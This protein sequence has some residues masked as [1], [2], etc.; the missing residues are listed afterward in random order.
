MTKQTPP[1][2]HLSWL[3][4]AV[5]TMDA[6]GVVLDRMFDGPEIPSQEDIQMA[7]IEELNDLRRRAAMPWIGMLENW[8]TALSERLG[9]PADALLEDGLLAT[10][11]SDAGVKVSFEDGTDL[12]FQRAFH[13]GEAPTT[14]DGTYVSHRV[15]VFSE[16]CG[17]HE[18]WLG[19]N[20]RIDV[21]NSKNTSDSKEDIDWDN[22]APVGREFGSPDYDRLM[23]EDA[24]KF[25]TDLRAW[26]KVSQES[27]DRDEVEYAM[28]E[29]SNDIHNIQLAL[30]QLGQ[31]V[32]LE[33]AASVWIHY[34]KSLCAGWMAG[35]DTV[36]SA[37]RALYL[38][39]ARWLP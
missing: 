21:F 30:G 3:D 22:M 12:V 28:R 17:Y 35:A 34:S 7:A 25:A 39:C 8:R 38:N 16:H 32:S 13:L 26:I 9:R 23:A 37:A 14:A 31:D 19:P 2:G 18:Y 36:K 10:D 33:A 6:R 15:A 20:D 5:A 27:V 11:F 24:A 4:Y 1:K 29:F